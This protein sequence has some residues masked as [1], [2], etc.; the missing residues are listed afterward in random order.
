MDLDA[1][2]DEGRDAADEQIDVPTQSPAELWCNLDE[3]CALYQDDDGMPDDMFD[4][5]GRLVKALAKYPELVTERV[6][7]TL[8]AEVR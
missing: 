3:L 6:L 4:F 7:A 2:D 8:Q 5:A 1:L